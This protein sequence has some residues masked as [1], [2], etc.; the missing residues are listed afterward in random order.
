MLRA[1]LVTGN[2]NHT[3]AWCCWPFLSLPTASLSSLLQ[4]WVRPVVQY[5]VTLYARRPWTTFLPLAIVLGVAMVKE[6]VEDYKRHKQD[7]EVNNRP[8]EVSTRQQQSQGGAAAPGKTAGALARMRQL[9]KQGGGRVC[10][11]DNHSIGMWFLQRGFGGQQ[12][13][14]ALLAEG[15]QAPRRR[16]LCCSAQL[17]APR[18]ANLAACC[19]SS[20]SCGACACSGHRASALSLAAADALHQQLQ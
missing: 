6:A 11:Q 15:R 17:P 1:G 7:V 12:P 4:L 18:G 2:S 9:L 8:V 16:T 19:Q 5:P 3:R 14:A 20:S 10:C 13:S